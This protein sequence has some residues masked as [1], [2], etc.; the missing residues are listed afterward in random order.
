MPNKSKNNKRKNSLNP[1][2]FTPGYFIS[3]FRKWLRAGLWHKLIAASLLAIIASLSCMY[4]ISQWYIY[5]HADE[6]LELGAT[7]I[8][9][10]AHA[11]G[12]DPE[13]TLDA[14]IN[15]LGIKRVRLVSYWENGEPEPGKYDFS[16][17]DWQFKKAEAAGVKVTLAIGLRQPRWPECHAPDWVKELPQEQWEKSLNNYMTEVVNR[18]KNKPNLISYQL[19]NEYFMQSFAKCMDHSR[20]RLVRE[21]N[22]I[23]KLDPGRP[24]IVSRSNNAAPTWPIGEPRADLVGI[25]VYKRVWDEYVTNRYLEYPIPAWY[26]GF[27]AGAT[28]LTTGRNTFVHEVQAESWLPVGMQM[29]TASTEELYKSMDPERLEHRFRYTI[30]TG[31]RQHDFWGAEWWYY[32]KMV[33]NKPELWETAKQQFKHYQ[34]TS[35]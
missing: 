11:L 15:E 26:Y 25:S 16:F 29:T 20:E 5:K 9:D 24:L 2:Q 6:P 22:L 1:Y 21:Y 27:L 18:Y 14:M 4:A 28:E 10:Y 34:Q 17:L 3:E 35:N 7:F 19:E 12:V 30:D 8:P 33:R 13:E 23:K 31:M 32:M